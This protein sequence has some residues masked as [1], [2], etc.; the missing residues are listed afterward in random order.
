L[1]TIIGGGIGASKLSRI[2]ADLAAYE[3]IVCDKSFEADTAHTRVISVG[4][5]EARNYLLQNG[6]SENIGYIVTGSPFFYS[7]AT[8]VMRGLR[9][10]CIPYSVIYAES[11]KDYLVRALQIPE[12]E[13]VA[14]SLHGREALDLRAF[15]SRKYTF[16][17]CDERT[18][19]KVAAI[20]NYLPK[21]AYK[22]TYAS[23]MGTDEE[24]IE[25]VC[26]E[27]LG[28][29]DWARLCPFV[30]LIEKL[31]ED[32]KP[33]TNDDELEYERGMYTKPYKRGLILQTLELAPNQTLWDVGAGS[34][35]VSIDAFKERSVHTVM[36]EKNDERRD[37][38]ERNLSS[39]FVL[40]AKVHRGDALENISKEPNGAD[41]IFVGGGGANLAKSLPALKE[42]LLA[43]GILVAAYVSME[44]LTL[45]IDSLRNAGIEYEIKSI[46]LTTYKEP[47]KI[48]EPER[49]MFLLK[50]RK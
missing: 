38:L 18:P 35:S 40:S 23:K 46:S 50:V 22:I 5:L 2:K 3:T 39:H 25:E 7:G 27:E 11:S 41:R 37:I 30:L 29:R 6:K 34:G 26:F 8:S 36:F 12:N 13:I 15:M 16:L 48:S 47:L 44:H 32:R 20:I 45:A 17:L 19:T 49:Q 4:F 21:E 10:A 1:V 31:Y 28:E 24:K 42:K 33:Y 9:E 14:L 43:D